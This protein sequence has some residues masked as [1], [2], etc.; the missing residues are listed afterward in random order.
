MT[1]L[2]SYYQT[3][4]KI[5]RKDGG[6]WLWGRRKYN[7]PWLLLGYRVTEGGDVQ[8]DLAGSTRDVRTE[9][10]SAAEKSAANRAYTADEKRLAAFAAMD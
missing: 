4:R 6:N 9:A 7:G 1:I 5:G 3:V 8:T 10:L 2:D